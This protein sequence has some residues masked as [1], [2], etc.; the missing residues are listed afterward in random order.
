MAYGLVLADQNNFFIGSGDIDLPARIFKSTNGGNIFVNQIGNEIPTTF[1]LSQNY[2][3]PFNPSTN[4]KL[5][6]ASSKF[7]KL[8]VYDILGKEVAVLV[9]EKLQAGEYETNFDGSN[10]P[11]RIYFY[12]LYADEKLNETKRM[13]LL[14]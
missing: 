1:S 14:K 5:K 3:N 12:S 10:L 2:P 8:V 6:V 4:I 9:N 7:I 11:S 13:L